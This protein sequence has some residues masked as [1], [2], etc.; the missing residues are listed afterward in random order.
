MR[1]S[2][3]AI[4]CDLAPFDA[5]NAPASLYI[6]SP[7]C[8]RRCPYCD[9]AIAVSRERS[10][11]EAYVEGLEREIEFKQLGGPLRTVFIG[12]GT[13]SALPFDL[14]ER[15]FG[16]IARRF[17]LSRVREFSLE[18][19]P[20]D[21]TPEMVRLWRRHGVDR[22]SLGAQ[23]LQERL[24]RLLGR[25]HRPDD[26]ARC[27]TLLRDAGIRRVGIDLIVAIPSE[28]D[29]ELARDLD[30]VLALQPDHVSVYCLTFEEGTPY[31]RAR[32]RGALHPLDE[33]AEL[34][35][36][37]TARDRLERGGLRQYEVSNYARPGARCI[38]NMVYWRNERYHGIGPSAASF[39]N[40]TRSKNEPSL[41]RWL[42]S[43]R[44]GRSPV[45]ESETLDAPHAL[46]ESLYLGLRMRR[47]VRPERLRARHGIG[48]EAIADSVWSHLFD[49]GLI[50]SAGSRLRL[51]ARGVEVADRVSQELLA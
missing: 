5:P 23:S 37:R 13:P 43:L 18:A 29:V 16:L 25:R 45:I 33:D 8:H 27:V 26:V 34:A 11:A 12:G 50:E 39:V 21:V 47:G 32:E 31:S 49:L 20:E 42:D 38:H 36:Y 3:A 48:P 14:Q 19:N 2:R 10:D 51:T 4:G 9:F 24:L 17:D 22:L 15:F 40:G 30:A 28:T 7:F 6:H 44:A 1:H 46:R 35:H 41:Q